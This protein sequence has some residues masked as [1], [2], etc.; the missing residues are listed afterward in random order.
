ML[1]RDGPLP[2]YHQ[3]INVLA[4]RIATG[5]YSLGGPFPSER[6]LI[7]E[8]QVSRITVRLALQKLVR[9]GLLRRERGRGS[10]LLA[11][12]LTRQGDRLASLD[13]NEL[14]I[15]APLVIREAGIRRLGARDK[16]PEAF[17][18]GAEDV[19]YRINRLAVLGDEVLIRSSIYVRLPAAATVTS[20]MLQEFR[21]IHSMIDGRFGI[22]IDHGTRT[23]EAVAAR[24]NES[25]ALGVPAGF[26]LLFV[27]T[28]S[29]DAV[30]RTLSYAET[31]YR[32]DRWQFVIPHVA[33]QGSEARGELIPVGS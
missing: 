29:V 9:D 23:V 27:R 20:R 13:E 14:A 32:G 18:L 19:L 22:K 5:R 24:R 21:S 25:Q 31:W 26:P 12:K 30:G 28:T 6:Q 8:F 7:G 33:R 15:Q 3:L 2:L 1:S 4:A 10:F 11:S 16:A 17:K